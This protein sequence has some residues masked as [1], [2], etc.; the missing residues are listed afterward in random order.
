MSPSIP[1]INVRRALRASP[2]SSPLHP[3]ILLPE[4]SVQTQHP[5][6]ILSI[7]GFTS[8]LKPS[9]GKRRRRG[10]KRRAEAE[11]EQERR[12]RKGRRK[13]RS[14]ISLTTGNV[15]A[16]GRSSVLEFVIVVWW[17]CLLLS[18][19]VLPLLKVAGIAQWLQRRTRDQR[20][21]VGSSPG[22]SGGRIFFSRVNILC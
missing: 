10:R 1:L 2:P 21:V 6:L 20:R 15:T 8:R 22:R 17:V 4:G 12:G 9:R 18:V 5:Q 16:S 3:S 13:R 14:L 11:G 19:L 7:Q